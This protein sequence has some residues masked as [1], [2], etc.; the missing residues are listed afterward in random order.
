MKDETKNT[1][2]A[3]VIAVAIKGLKTEENAVCKKFPFR[4]DKNAMYLPCGKKQQEVK[5]KHQP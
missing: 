2:I 5:I 1:V 4:N 3:T